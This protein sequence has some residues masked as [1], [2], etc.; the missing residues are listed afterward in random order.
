M[1]PQNLVK[2]LPMLEGAT[3]I[4]AHFGAYAMWPESM[5]MLCGR[6]IYFD[7]AFS[8][9]RI[10]LKLGAEIVRRHG[11]DR[12]LLGSDSPW[13]S[14]SDEIRFVSLM[15]IPEHDKDKILKG[16]A[17]RLIAGRI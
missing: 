5:D 9:G 4:A 6:D 8:C 7:T 3:V 13:A 15:D 16:N 12:V 10:P 11:A 14:Q 17:E 1:T 2:T